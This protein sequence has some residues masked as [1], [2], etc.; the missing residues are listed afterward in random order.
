MPIGRRKLIAT[1]LLGSIAAWLPST[2][3][4]GRAFKDVGQLR[5]AV[6]AAFRAA[7]GVG[8]VRADPEDLAKF[9]VVINGATVTSDLTNLFGYLAAYPDEDAD[10]AIARF[11]RARVEGRDAP[12]RDET[13]VAVIRS[14]AYLEEAKRQG[15]EVLQEPAGADLFVVYMADRP[16]SMS[17][18]SA[19]DIPDKSLA[20]ARRV[21]LGNVR[22]WL[23]KVVADGGLG[24]GVLYYVEGNTLLSPSLLLVDE[25]WTSVA[26]RFPGDVLFAIPRKDQLFIFNDDGNSRTEA[27]ARGLIKATLDE[28]FNLLSPT[29][30]AR[31]K[32]RIVALTDTW[33]V[34]GGQG[35]RDPAL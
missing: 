1:G 29:L 21:A 16:D 22:K 2:A 9:S 26:V 19:K 24:G 15:V 20:D 7:P 27:L 23:P 28:G 17:P 33:A 30:Y 34:V 4:Q 25:F 3:A 6:M 11:V 31:R 32:G 35:A 8:Q 12:V 18:I 14:R 10:E 13:L 5:E